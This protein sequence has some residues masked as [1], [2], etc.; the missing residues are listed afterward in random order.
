M[1]KNNY[2]LNQQCINAFLELKQRV[3]FV[4]LEIDDFGIKIANLLDLPQEVYEKNVK[5]HFWAFLRIFLRKSKIG[6][7]LNQSNICKNYSFDLAL[8]GKLDN[9]EYAIPLWIVNDQ[10]L[11]FEIIESKNYSIIDSEL[12]RWVPVVSR[13]DDLKNE[14]TSLI[15]ICEDI[16]LKNKIYLKIVQRTISVSNYSNDHE[17]FNRIADTFIPELDE[18]LYKL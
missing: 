10:L 3:W 16:F 6:F 7:I 11:G 4:E 9:N 2:Q 1:V 17:F 5:I 13:K 15:M 14:K 12:L 8:I 18:K